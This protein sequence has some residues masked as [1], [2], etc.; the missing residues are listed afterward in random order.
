[1]LQR[2]LFSA[3]FLLV[4][5]A[6]GS[7]EERLDGNAQTTRPISEQPADTTPP[8]EN[9]L[10]FRRADGS[11]IEIPGR[12]VAWCGPDD[13][14][15]GTVLQVAAIESIERTAAA[16]HSSFWHVRAAPKDIRGGEP[17]SFPLKPDWEGRRGAA[18]FAYD[19]S[20]ENEASTAG[21]DS[22]GRILFRRASCE[23]G[24]PIEFEVDAVIDSEF[25]DGDAV[26]ATGIFRGVLDDPPEGYD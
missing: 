2:A 10:L 17:I 22:S 24:A 21:E 20:T 12:P 8:S 25:L 14:Y 9:N 7:N 4:A 16:L 18:V 19:A 11:E 3:L 6:C 13:E 5:A 23:V 1:M 26:T 15:P